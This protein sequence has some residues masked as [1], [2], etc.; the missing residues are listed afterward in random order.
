MQVAS[1]ETNDIDKWAFANYIALR[2]PSANPLHLC[3]N[4]LSLV[5]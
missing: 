1:V 3:N 5:G 4:Q 2:V